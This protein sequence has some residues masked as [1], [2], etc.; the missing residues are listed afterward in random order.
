MRSHWPSLGTLVFSLCVAGSAAAADRQTPAATLAGFDAEELPQFV[1]FTFD[2]NWVVDRIHWANQLY[3]PLVNPPGNGVANNYDGTPVRTTFFSNSVY[4]DQNGVPEV[5]RESFDDGHEIANHTD[6]HPNGRDGDF[7]EA[8]W[9]AQMSLCSDKMTDPVSGVGPTAILGF[10]TPYLA[11]NTATFEALASL[12]FEFDSTLGAC[13]PDNQDGSNC[14]F[15]YT[16]DA[17]SPDASALHDKYAEPAVGNHAG[18]WETPVAT[19][20]V[21]PDSLASTYGFTPGLRGRIPTSMPDPSHYEPETG[22]LGGLDYTAFVDAG[23][24]GPEF[25]ATLKYTFDLRYNG[26]RAPMVVVGHTHVYSSDERKQALADFLDYVLSKP[27]VR[28]RPVRDIVEWMRHPT[29]LTGKGPRPVVAPS[30]GATGSGGTDG[31]ATGGSS[32]ALG[33]AGGDASADDGAATDGTCSCRAAGS[34]TLG[35]REAWSGVGALLGLWVLR[36]RL[37]SP[38]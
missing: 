29:S 27:E 16:L 20:I 7:D 10:R 3:S 30:G 17:G 12:G 36:R 22:K 8:A 2:D 25:L 34:P 35:G 6:G 28:V 9:A 33:G 18:L 5:W 4:L 13:W 31:A 1:A 26:N 14:L 23:M 32:T 21:P 24:T 19:F 37:R 15:P 38:A 11:Y